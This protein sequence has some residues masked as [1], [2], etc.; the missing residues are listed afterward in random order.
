MAS[1]QTPG[2]AGIIAGGFGTGSDRQSRQQGEQVLRGS[3]LQVKGAERRD[4]VA[5]QLEALLQKLLNN[6][7]V[8][9]AERSTLD[10]A[11][12]IADQQIQKAT[13]DSIA[14]SL[15]AQA[16]TGFLKGERTQDQ[17]RK[18]TM[19]GSLGRQQIA[20]AREQ[21]IQNMVDRNKQFALQAGGL[22]TGTGIPQFQQFQFGPSARDQRN[23]AIA[24]AGVAAAGM[25]ASQGGQPQQGQPMES[26]VMMSAPT[27]SPFAGSGGGSSN[28]NV[29]N[30][31]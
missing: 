8:S 26:T 23:S 17:I 6:D 19:E 20:V 27:E 30:T 4:R 13:K 16:G 10:R 21:Q 28:V 25:F 9:A 7:P 12:K 24:Q 22:I 14:Q 1:I 18:L 29:P 11:T 5:G 31:G 2:I 15:Q 3:E